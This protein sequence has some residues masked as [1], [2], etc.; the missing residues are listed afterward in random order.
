MKMK[1]KFKILLAFPILLCSASA[2]LL[3]EEWIPVGENLKIKGYYNL[4]GEIVDVIIEEVGSTKARINESGVFVVQI[5]IGNVSPGQFYPIKVLHKGEILGESLVWITPERPPVAVEPT[6]CPTATPEWIP[7]CIA[8]EKGFIE[9]GEKIRIT[10]I[11]DGLPPG[12]KFNLSIERIGTKEVVVGPNHTFEAE[13]EITSKAE[14]GTYHNITATYGDVEVASSQIFIIGP[15]PTPARRA[16]YPTQTPE[17]ALPTPTPGFE[18]VLVSGL[19]IL[20]AFAKFR[21]SKTDW[22]RRL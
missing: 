3:H 22:K 5:R 9:I 2:T 1:W 7:F 11:A 20:Y 15:E 17:P 8:P 10:G 16:I 6:P 14:P 12:A 18:V 4:P 21:K 13:F 19:L